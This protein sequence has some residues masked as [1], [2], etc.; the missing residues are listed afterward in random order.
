MFSRWTYKKCRHFRFCLGKHSK[1]F[2]FITNAM[3]YKWKCIT[4][5]DKIVGIIVPPAPA[6]SPLRHH[7]GQFPVSLTQ[8]FLC[9]FSVVLLFCLVVAGPMVWMNESP[10]C[11]W[12]FLFAVRILIVDAVWLH[13]CVFCSPNAFYLNSVLKIPYICI[14]TNKKAT[15]LWSHACLQSL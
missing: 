11:T 7:I 3:N 2:S 10:C 13:M 5:F 8:A 6:P 12:F 4:F 15:N 9:D 14:S 1:I